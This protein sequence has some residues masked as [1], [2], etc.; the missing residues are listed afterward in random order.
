M[1]P[2][3][4][5]RIEAAIVTLDLA[6]HEFQMQPPLTLPRHTLYPRTPAVVHFAIV[7]PQP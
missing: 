6:L 4:R 3:R 1:D 2:D 5:A 7:P